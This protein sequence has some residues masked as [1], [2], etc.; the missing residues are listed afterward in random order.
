[1][2]AFDEILGWDH[3]GTETPVTPLEDLNLG[4]SFHNPYERL[5]YAEL[6][7]VSRY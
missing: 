7:V 6:M 4:V 5:K 1:M 3:R 2:F